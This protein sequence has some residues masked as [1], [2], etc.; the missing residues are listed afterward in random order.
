MT[1]VPPTVTND[2]ELAVEKT[3]ASAQGGQMELAQHLVARRAFME[4]DVIIDV[5]TADEAGVPSI[6]IGLGC[7]VSVT[8]PRLTI[9]VAREQSQTLLDVLAVTRRIAVVFG[10]APAHEAL[11]IKGTDCLI[12]PATEADCSVADAYVPKLVRQLGHLGF[13]PEQTAVYAGIPVTDLVALRFTPTA[14]FQQTPGPQ[15]GEPLR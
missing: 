5:A 3:R 9:L 10:H 14:V 1:P 8:P 11:Q 12:E 4:G 13:G 15:A 7:L 6:A 2:G